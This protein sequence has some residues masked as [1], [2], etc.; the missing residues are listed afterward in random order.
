MLASRSVVVG[1][2]L[3]VA[4]ST[5]R[6]QAAGRSY[7][8]PHVGIN[9]DSDDALIGAQFTFPI[10][11][12]IEFYPSADI[13]FPNAGSL[14]GLSMDLKF[15]LATVQGPHFYLGGGLNVLHS[16]FR[17]EGHSDAGIDLMFGIESRSGPVHP[18]GEGR[19]LIHDNT[20]F[21]LVGGLNFAL[22][23]R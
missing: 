5:A 12:S 20:S 1:V 3:L 9:F 6:S 21:Q 4:A 16:S 7:F 22:G 13:Y 2:L 17:G 14:L 8:G 19:V 11:N 23:G 15:G 18:F 10:T